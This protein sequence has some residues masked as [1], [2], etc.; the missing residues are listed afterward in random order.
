MQAILDGAQSE[1]SELSETLDARAA[2]DLALLERSPASTF[3]LYYMCLQSAEEGN[4]GEL[5]DDE[6]CPGSR[7]PRSKRS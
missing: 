4:L 3:D 7:V 2:Q 1:T 5:L 6:S